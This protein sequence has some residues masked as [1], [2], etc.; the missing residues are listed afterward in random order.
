M[1]SEKTKQYLNQ[2]SRLEMQIKNKLE[3]ISR[4]RIM[5]DGISGIS[6]GDKVQTSGSK[7]KMSNIV[8]K[9]VDMEREIDE[10][11]DKRCLII[12]QIEKMENNK[13]Y[14]I[15]TQIYVTQKDLKVIAFEK[16][17]GYRH[18]QRLRDNALEEFERLYG[19][20]IFRIP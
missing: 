18:I 8:S 9:I 12:E 4:L 10:M 17:R 1:D 16:K 14:D 15:L 6:D 3:E 7:D 20:F 11:I 19:D 13:Y 2:I 5:S